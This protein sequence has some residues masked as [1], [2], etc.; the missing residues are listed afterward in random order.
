MNIKTL[1]LLL[2]LILTLD[3]AHAQEMETPFTDW[4]KN[5][6]PV[7]HKCLEELIFAKYGSED[8]NQNKYMIELQCNAFNNMLV[9]MNSDDANWE[10]LEKALVYGCTYK[11]SDLASLDW[12]EW[13]QTDWT[14]VEYEYKLLLDAKNTSNKGQ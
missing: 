7:S 1:L 2:V 3:F 13:P 10:I 6:F 14:K 12:W 5:E 4:V 8:V 11:G 9:F